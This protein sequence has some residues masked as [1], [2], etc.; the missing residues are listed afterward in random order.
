[1]NDY[2]LDQPWCIN[3]KGD[4]PEAFRSLV[5]QFA[6]I[7]G[8]YGMYLTS[9]SIRAAANKAKD[10]EE[11]LDNLSE[12]TTLHQYRDPRIPYDHS[13]YSSILKVLQEASKYHP[14]DLY[15]HMPLGVGAAARMR[16]LRFLSKLQLPFP[17]AICRLPTTR[18]GEPPMTFIW[19]TDW[20]GKPLSTERGG[21]GIRV[22]S[23]DDVIDAN[24][25]VR[26]RLLRDVPIVASRAMLTRFKAKVNNLGKFSPSLLIF[27]YHE[28]T[29]RILT[30]E[31]GRR[32]R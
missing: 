22:T 10:L 6:D 12:H 25:L 26:D 30:P 29:G 32:D 4:Q 23:M 1:M 21:D 14:V 15:P 24:I 16:R 2:I 19:K 13:K 9:A 5:E 20:V 3:L 31:H 27:L 8:N 28:A 17:I 18:R 11:K 7:L